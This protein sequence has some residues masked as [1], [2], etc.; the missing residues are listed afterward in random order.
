ME[1]TKGYISA[2][3]YSFPVQLLVLHIKKNQL[4]LIY[5]LLLLALVLSLVGSKFG[6]PYLFLDPEYLGRVDYRSTFILGF[7]FGGFFM[8]FNISSYI[9]NGF[10]FPFL[11][12]TKKPFQK[13]ALNNFLLPLS[14]ICLYV[15]RF[16]HF[17]TTNEYQSTSTA[18]F[19]IISFLVG[20]SLS[21]FL[22]MLLFLRRGKVHFTQSVSPEKELQVLAALPKTN[23]EQNKQARALL[24]EWRVDNYLLN[25]FTVR[26][27]R[28]TAHYDKQQLLAL[29]RKDHSKA[30]LVELIV[31]ASIIT[32][33]MLREQALL[34]IPA[35]A[36][37]LLFFTL[38][39]FLT[40][41]MRYWLRGWSVSVA[42]LLLLLFNAASS[43]DY[44]SDHNKAYGLDYNLHVPY[45]LANIK[46]ITTPAR[47]EQDFQS[48]LQVLEKWKQKNSLLQAGKEKPTMVLLCTSGGGLRSALWT[49]T[50]LQEADKAT[51]G[52]LF[53]AT[54][55]ICGASGGMIGAAYFRELFLRQQR[56]QQAKDSI[57][58]PFLRERLAS[59]LLNP[60]T[61][62]MAVNDLL[63]SFQST[64]RY[65]H[66]RAYEFESTLN[67][68][69]QGILDKSLG[70]Y[71][72]PEHEAQIPMLV[73]KPTIINDGRQLIISPLPMSYLSAANKGSAEGIEFTR[74]FEKQQ[75]L[76]TRFTSLLRM[77][78]TFPYIL[79]TVSLPSNPPMEVMDAGMRDNFGIQSTLD[80]LYVFRDWIAQNTDRVIILQIRDTH[81]DAELSSDSRTT[82]IQGLFTPLEHFYT[83]FARIQEYNQQELLRY[84]E[85]WFPG[86]LEHVVFRQPERKEKVSLSWHLTT[87]EKNQVTS[88]MQSYENRHQLNNLKQLLR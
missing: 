53:P 41:A 40:S 19:E 82:L 52:K 81:G 80:F 63:P 18:I 15:E 5:W 32:M 78:A 7:A 23:K 24:K 58:S 2:I 84:A 73:L 3:Y 66:D 68:N 72:A 50:V 77:N 31:F 14:F 88:A 36:S 60:I 71:A 79:P 21:I 29:S 30:A 70:D 86:K 45:R 54:Q 57:Y 25:P 34:R 12:A 76:K 11:A 74:F 67:L 20:L 85:S 6:I 4:L 64:G 8:A 39:I 26:L 62:S 37:V 9:L 35:G 59:D 55:L 51:Q 16:L 87:Q 69:T 65:R 1:K 38:I 42:I 43:S 75:P 17:Q 22:T 27:T 61:F 83:N 10:R 47:Y 28:S 33:G 48:T 44:F 13:Y 56:E 49:L 46:A